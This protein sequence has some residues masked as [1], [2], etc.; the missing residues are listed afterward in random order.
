MNLF[1]TLILDHGGDE[2]FTRDLLLTLTNIAIN[3]K[4]KSLY[5]AN[6]ELPALVMHIITDAITSLQN[7]KFATQM[8]VNLFYKST[9][10]ISQ[11]NR[12]QITILFYKGQK[13]SRNYHSP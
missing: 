10:S 1:I 3:R 13:S 4:T 8:L 9:Q 12:Y 7:K 5:L 2:P 6:T 11:F